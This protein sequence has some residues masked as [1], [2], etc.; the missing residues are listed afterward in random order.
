MWKILFFTLVVLLG[1]NVLLNI[2]TVARAQVMQSGSYQ[3]QSDSINFGGGLS[4]STN[5]SLESTGG[6]VATGDSESSSYKLKAGYQQMQEVYLSLSGVAAVSM[7]P[8]IPG[9]TGG[10][11]NGST[12]ATAIT[13]SPSGYKLTIE[14]SNSPAMKDGV[15]TIADYVS[16]GTPTY[17]F[18]TGASDSHFGYSVSGVD[19]VARFKDNGASCNQG[20]NNTLL[21][22][23]EG[24]SNTATTSVQ[25]TSPNHPNGATTTVYFRV[26]VGSSVLQTPGAYIATTT[27]TLLAL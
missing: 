5:Y 16:G 23:W 24:L 10:I 9:V 19:I 7:T 12:T 17:D 1:G 13:D 21:K 8:S 11:A 14:S 2:G 22:C 27:L 18:N 26:G 25:S 20:G 3:I 15:N 4:T 6:E